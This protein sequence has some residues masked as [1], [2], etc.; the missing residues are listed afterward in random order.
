MRGRDLFF[1]WPK[2]HPP[3]NRR[4]RSRHFIDTISQWK[5]PL[6]RCFFARRM[7]KPTF[8]RYDRNIRFGWG[9]IH[10]NYTKSNRLQTGALLGMG[11]VFAWREYGDACRRSASHLRLRMPCEPASCDARRFCP[12]YTKS[13]RLPT[14]ACCFW[15]RWRESNPRSQLG[16]LKFY[17]WTTSATLEIGVKNLYNSEE[18]S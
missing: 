13:N 14:G 4:R 17:H 5:A 6:L 16:K 12:Y 11:R 18:W 2:L 7:K 15:S 8:L 10:L 1:M 9:G 3:Q